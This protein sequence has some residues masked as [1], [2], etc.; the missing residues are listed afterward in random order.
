MIMKSVIAQLHIIDP[1]GLPQSSADQSNINRILTDL[2]ITLG[3]VAFLM[4]VIAG[5]RYIFARGNPEA[6][7]R[8][9]NMIIYSLVGLII[10]ASAAAIVNVVLGRVK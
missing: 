1:E 3:A 10:A 6:I 7:T 8:A 5:M 2:F 9:R 4:L